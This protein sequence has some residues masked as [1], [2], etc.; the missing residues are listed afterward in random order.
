MDFALSTKKAKTISEAKNNRHQRVAYNSFFA[1]FSFNQFVNCG[2]FDMLP[3]AR[4]SCS[5][6]INFWSDIHWDN[7]YAM[8]KIDSFMNNKRQHGVEHIR[9]HLNNVC[10]YL[11]FTLGEEDF[12]IDL[13]ANETDNRRY[14]WWLDITQFT[15]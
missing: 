2:S 15:A 8:G 6:L 3:P 7:R 1:I 14:S 4:M 10:V 12:A 11:N 5:T 9:T 13:H